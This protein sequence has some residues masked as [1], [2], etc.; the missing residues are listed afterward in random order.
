MENFECVRQL[1]KYKANIN[2]KCCRSWQPTALAQAVNLPE[3]AIFHYLLQHGVCVTDNGKQNIF[4]LM[5]KNM[6]TRKYLTALFAAGAELS[7]FVD[8]Q[9]FADD[10]PVPGLLQLSR[11]AIRKHI[12][13]CNPDSNLYPFIQHLPLPKLL[14]SYLLYDVTIERW[15]TPKDIVSSLK[16]HA[17]ESDADLLTLQKAS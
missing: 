3:P 17:F 15:F 9:D 13:E 4:Q 7:N 6:I 16:S 2:Q 10:T 8:L 1:I 14:M 5:P 12:L 11:K